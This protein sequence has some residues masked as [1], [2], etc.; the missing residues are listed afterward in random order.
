MKLSESI[1]IIK[2]LADSSR[3]MI[4]HALIEKP[5][6]V[7]ELS[8]RLDLAASTV[9]FHLKKLETA[10]L[11][12]KIKEQYYVMYH[13]NHDALAMTLRDLLSVHDI[14]KMIQEERIKQY[15]QKVIRTFF[16]D[17]ILQKMP[18]QQKKRRIILEEFAKLFEAG[19]TY[20]E[21]E[22]NAN[23]SKIYEDYC[24][25]R[26]ELVDLKI[27]ARKQ[28]SYW[29]L[30]EL[31]ES[32]SHLPPQKRLHQRKK[33]ARDRRKALKREY[34]EN[35]LAGVF[36]ITNTS[37][38]KI[39]IGK[40][41]NGKGKLNSHQAQLKMGVHRNK[42]LQQDWNHYGAEQFTF[43]VLDYLEFRD[44]SPQKQQKDLLALEKLW[45]DKLRPYGEK[46]YNKKPKRKE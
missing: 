3:L 46:G 38:G 5:Q 44:D 15:R 7:E 10:H 30:T 12:Y 11:V 35:T 43:E 24:L 36:Q 25:I 29:L 41:M 26:R 9:S 28:G 16:K 32:T 4:M 13:A 42:G 40:G 21:K 14:E 20:T 17:R 23:I 34:K 33:K 8:E 39:F 27:M 18:A 6:Y 37:N 31:A 2:A 1:E 22:V 19:R 45:L